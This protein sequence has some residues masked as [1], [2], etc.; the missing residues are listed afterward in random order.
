MDAFFSLLG[1]TSHLCLSIKHHL[2]SI[3][4]LIISLSGIQS[5]LSDFRMEFSSEEALDF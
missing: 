1:I 3:Q 2:D 4:S 5:H